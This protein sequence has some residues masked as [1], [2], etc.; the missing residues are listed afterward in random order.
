MHLIHSLSRRLIMISYR[1]QEVTGRQ[2]YINTSQCSLDKSTNDNTV[3]VSKEND[4]IHMFQ[5]VQ[6]S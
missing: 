1:Q 5:L 3:R 2:R 6:K 4:L